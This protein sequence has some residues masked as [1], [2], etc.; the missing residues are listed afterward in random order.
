MNIHTINILLLRPSNWD[1][2]A[3][4]SLL[5]LGLLVNI[6]VLW[7]SETLGSYVE[8]GSRRAIKHQCC[9]HIPFSVKYMMFFQGGKWVRT[10][11]GNCCFNLCLVFYVC[12]Y[13]MYPFILNL[14]LRLDNTVWAVSTLI[15]WAEVAET[16]ELRL[17][18]G[19]GDWEFNVRSWYNLK[20]PSIRTILWRILTMDE[21][22]FGLRRLEPNGAG[23]VCRCQHF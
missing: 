9:T 1:A 4:S 5:K 17:I 12:C 8:G 15:T 3:A 21:I 7:D 6:R 13:H 14:W 2:P 11:Y 19:N 18:E 10:V 20:Q 23:P 16:E 22:C